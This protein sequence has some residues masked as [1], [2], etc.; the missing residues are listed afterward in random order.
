[1]SLEDGRGIRLTDV[2]ILVL[3]CLHPEAGVGGQ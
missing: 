2:G 1:M 3:K